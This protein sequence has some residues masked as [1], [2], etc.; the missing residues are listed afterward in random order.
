M[1]HTPGGE[2]LVYKTADGRAQVEVRLDQETVWLTQDQMSALFGRERSV[3]TKHIRNVF[4]EGELESGAVCANFAHTAN[5][6]KTYQVDHYNLDVIISIGYRAVSYTHLD[7][8]KRQGHLPPPGSGSS[9]RFPGKE[10]G[11]R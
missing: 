9:H 1:E 6:G 8:Y 4:R 3:I 10:D 11:G 2:V 7:V 5:D